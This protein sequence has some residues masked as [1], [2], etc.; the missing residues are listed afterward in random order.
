MRVGARD[1]R[2]RAVLRRMVLATPGCRCRSHHGLTRTSQHTPVRAYVLVSACTCA[3][4]L[5]VV[6]VCS[7][8]WGVR[9]FVCLYDYGCERTCAYLDSGV[10]LLARM[11]L[12]AGL[13]PQLVGDRKFE[14]MRVTM[15]DDNDNNIIWI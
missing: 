12:S 4:A 13:P 6:Y 5:V 8:V 3:C 2:G 14:F 10:L 9:V 7:Y 11:G 15:T 1:S